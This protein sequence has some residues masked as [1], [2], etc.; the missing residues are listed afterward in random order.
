MTGTRLA[1]LLCLVPWWLGAASQAA[2]AS[3]PTESLLTRIYPKYCTESGV[4]DP[5]PE[6][7][8]DFDAYMRDHDPE[9]YAYAVAQ[10]W[11]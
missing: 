9:L 6:L 10:G 3:Q 1:W 11:S 2:N 8:C 4:W 5:L 7:M